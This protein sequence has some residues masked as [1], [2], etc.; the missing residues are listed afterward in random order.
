M[1][2]PLWNLQVLGEDFHLV[3]KTEIEYSYRNSDTSLSI[4]LEH[5][6]IQTQG[7][8]SRHRD[9]SDGLESPGLGKIQPRGTIWQFLN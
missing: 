5:L 6:V 4:D 2:I 9:R 7:T 8:E 1:P 3:K